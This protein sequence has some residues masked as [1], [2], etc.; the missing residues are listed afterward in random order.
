MRSEN[1]RLAALVL[2]SKDK[3]RFNLSKNL[4]VYIDPAKT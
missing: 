2:I 1:K 4:F 3:L